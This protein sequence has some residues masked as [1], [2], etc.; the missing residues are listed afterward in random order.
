MIEADVKK[1]VK[2]FLKERGAWW[3][4]PVPGG[5]SRRTVDFLICYRGK[6]IACETKRPPEHST[7]PVTTLQAVDLY[8]V[9]QAGGYAII[10]NS[11]ELETLRAVFAAIEN[12]PL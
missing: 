11:V 9:R 7:Y 12:A 5:Y 1:A 8:N 3:F 10:E 4:M 2:A 6:F